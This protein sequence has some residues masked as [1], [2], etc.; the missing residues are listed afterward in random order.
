MENPK[1]SDDGGYVQ[2]LGQTLAAA[3]DEPYK[4]YWKELGRF[5]HMFSQTEQRLMALLAK[6][7]GV[8][9]KI[10]GAIFSGTRAESGKDLINRVLDATGRS[11]VK[12]RLEYPL[13]QL[14]VINTVRN[15]LVHW[16]AHHDGSPDL[17]V[18]N[19]FQSPI[20]DRLTEFRLGPKD[21]QAMQHDLVKIG[22]FFLLEQHPSPE[23]G[24]TVRPEYD[25]YLAEPW[26]YKRPPQAPH[27]TER[28]R[29]ARKR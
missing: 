29:R 15:N 2:R 7:V 6:I 27:E 13:A 25:D 1:M 22:F 21:M 8:N 18:S 5:I 3:A 28:R 12:K 16:G 17:L 20:P 26:L 19:S 11:D 9:S 4:E 14:G 24:D 10:A 23:T